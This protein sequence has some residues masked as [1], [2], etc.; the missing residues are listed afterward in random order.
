MKNNCK[1]KAHENKI[2]VI[3]SEEGNDSQSNYST[4]GISA[5]CGFNMKL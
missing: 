1:N 2:N 3:S 5:H 4:L